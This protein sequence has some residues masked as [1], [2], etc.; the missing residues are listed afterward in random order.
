MLLGPAVCTSAFPF[1]LDS[2]RCFCGPLKERRRRRRVCKW[3]SPRR[4]RGWGWGRL[5]FCQMCGCYLALGKGVCTSAARD[6]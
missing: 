5:S 2:P 4:I 3:I 1:N 6:V